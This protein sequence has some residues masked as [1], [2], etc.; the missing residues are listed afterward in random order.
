MQINTAKTQFRIAL[1]QTTP[2]WNDYLFFLKIASCGNLQAAALE[3]GVNP[4]TAYRRINGLEKRLK[5]RLFDRFK[6]GYVLTSAGEDVFS[7][8]CQVEEQMHAIQRI[9]EGRDSELCGSL[10]ISTTDTLG[11]YWLPPYI[12]RFKELYPDI[13]IDLGIKT[14]YT[15]MN[16]R[17]ADIVI[18]AVNMQPDYMVG[19]KL[20]VLFFQLCASKAYIQSYGKPEKPADFSKHKFLLPNETL[21]GL[22]A[23][24]WI[25][26]MVAEKNIVACSDRF[27]ALYHL[28]RQGLGLTMLPFYV[29]QRDPEIEPILRLPEH[30]NHQVWIL[31]HPDLRNSGRVRAFMQ[32][33]SAALNRETPTP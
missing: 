10:K 14:S 4:S 9:I 20:F 7:R 29:I 11:Y 6:T 12:R 3:L 1:M 21:A 19:R 33:I 18:P 8:V 30:C 25:R 15:D 17:E 28:A 32:F 2:D 26:Q 23:S 22:S 27:T 31:T 5:V 16:R 13:V 24:K